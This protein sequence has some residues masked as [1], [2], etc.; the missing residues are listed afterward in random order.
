MNAKLA[1]T[2]DLFAYGTYPE[3]LQN[4]ANYIEL[5]P[6][7]LS[8]L[9]L[10]TLVDLASKNAKVSYQSLMQATSIETSRQLEDCLIE[11]M[12]LGLLKG[13]LD[14]REQKL[15]VQSTFGR[16]VS[17]SAVP[18]I[19][20]RLKQWDTQLERTQ[21]TMESQK[22]VSQA[23]LDA[24]YSHMADVQRSISSRME[25]A[26]FQGQVDVEMKQQK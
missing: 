21:Q 19:L 14:Q 8:K 20:A 11:C 6:P 16:D 5:K 17:A 25:Q 10:I 24:H 3:Y 4:K 9:K 7:H 2:L 23:D 18:N 22:N 12:Q 1:A 15:W 26:V 13:R